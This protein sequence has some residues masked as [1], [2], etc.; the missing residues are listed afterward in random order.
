MNIDLVPSDFAVAVGVADRK[1]EGLWLP[2]HERRWNEI[3]S[4]SQAPNEFFM[5]RSPAAR[6]SVPES[7]LA[8]IHSTAYYSKI[9]SP[10]PY[11]LAGTRRYSIP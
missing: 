7:L 11:P 10:V 3:P 9:V 6:F 5:S 4:P 2:F 1:I 8:H